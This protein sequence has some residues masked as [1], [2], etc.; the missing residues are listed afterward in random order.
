MHPKIED[1]RAEMTNDKLSP[2]TF[3]SIVVKFIRIPL[4][5]YTIR[6]HHRQIEDNV[7]LSLNFPKNLKPQFECHP[8]D[9]PDHAN[10]A[11]H[12]S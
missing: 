5:L 2:I 6:H 10:E 12:M 1:M 7:P 11:N 3:L 4:I 8:F 9:V